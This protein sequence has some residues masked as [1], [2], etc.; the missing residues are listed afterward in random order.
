MHAHYHGF[1]TSQLRALTASPTV[2]RTLY[3]LRTALT[4]AHLL[5]TAELVT[6][7]T[8]L[9]DDHG[10]TEARELVNAKLRGER[11]VLG[12]A[13][14]IRWEVV[15]ARAFAELDEAAKSSV[16]PAEPP[17]AALAALERWLIATRRATF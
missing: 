12:E 14:R 11:T 4:G 16:L 13:E 10:F 9:L 2:K 15:L 3:V 1:A 5:R 6:D 8:K 7:V 17:P